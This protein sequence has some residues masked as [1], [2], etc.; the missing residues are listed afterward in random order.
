MRPRKCARLDRPVSGSQ[1]ACRRSSSTWPACSSNIAL[2]RPTIAFIAR[3]TLRSSGMSGSSTVTKRRSVIALAWSTVRSS[4]TRMRLTPTVRED[5]RA[6]H[7]HQQHA[8]RVDRALPQLVVGERRL[9]AHLEAADLAPAVADLRH[10][11]RGRDAQQRDEPAGRVLRMRRRPASRRASCRRARRGG[12]ARSSRCRTGSRW[13]APAPTGSPFCC[14]SVSASD[15]AVS[16][17]FRLS[18]VCR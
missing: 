6:D 5:A 16:L 4:G 9:A 7:Q 11:V 12:C 18:C 3:V 10:A 17:F 14:D 1:C 15:C 8:D 13:P 2:T